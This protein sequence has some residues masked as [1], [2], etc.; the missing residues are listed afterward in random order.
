VRALASAIGLAV[1]VG[2]VVL[3][4]ALG[5]ASEWIGPL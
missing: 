2:M 5:A 1:A 3:S 4:L